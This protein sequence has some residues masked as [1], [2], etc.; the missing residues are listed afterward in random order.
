MERAGS[1][2]GLAA[3]QYAPYFSTKPQEAPLNKDNAYGY[4]LP[5]M[6]SMLG[7]VAQVDT[8]QG[9]RRCFPMIMMMS[10]MAGLMGGA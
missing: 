6:G 1:L 4:G 7:Q 2:D 8:S 9:G 3:K 5:A 10:L